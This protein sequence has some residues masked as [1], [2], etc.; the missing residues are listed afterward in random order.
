MEIRQ[1]GKYA[2]LDHMGK[3][4]MANV[5]RACDN[6]SGVIVAIKIFESTEERPPD[7]SRKFRDRELHM[8]LSVQHPNI[9]RFFETGEI[10]DEFFYAME[11]VEDS[12]LR[13]MRQKK[14]FDLL[15]KIHI[16]RQTANAQLSVRH[17]FPSQCQ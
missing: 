17:P 9:V 11:F 2:L 8:L 16:L 6:E 13:C 7:V 10:E 5:Y 15:T 4:G 14:E 1:F 12:L 3:G